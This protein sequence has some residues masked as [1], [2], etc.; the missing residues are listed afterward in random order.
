M[1]VAFFGA[2]VFDDAVLR[3]CAA[4]AREPN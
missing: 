1:R 2:Q 4:A 3:A